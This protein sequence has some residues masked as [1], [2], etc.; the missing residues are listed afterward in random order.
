MPS[1]VRNSAHQDAILKLSD[2][3]ISYETRKGDVPAVRG[4]SMDVYRGRTL[5]LVGE[6]GCGKST[7]AFGIVDFLGANGKIVQGG[8][9]FQEKNLVGLPSEQLRQIRG[10]QIAMVYQDPMQALN[11][12]LSVGSQLAEALVFH[13]ELTKK[14]ARDRSIE[15]LKRVYMPQLF[16]RQANKILLLKRDTPLDDFSIC[17]EK[18]DDSKG[19]RTFAAS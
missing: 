7:I 17:A 11:P 19:N 8:I 5:G 10:N 12:S 18:I 9:S 16:S 1:G 6:S 14:E 2:I 4:V 3:Y 13:Q 15:M